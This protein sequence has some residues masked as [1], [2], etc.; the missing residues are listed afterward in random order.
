MAGFQ[1]QQGTAP[2]G[3]PERTGPASSYS[4]GPLLLAPLAA[5]G[6]TVREADL[7]QACVQDTGGKLDTAR[8]PL[9][10]CRKLSVPVPGGRAGP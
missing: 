8:R 3:S 9:G 2:P 4:T 10:V 1:E 5:A 6:R 7:P